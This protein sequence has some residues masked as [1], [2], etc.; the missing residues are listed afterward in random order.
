MNDSVLQMIYIEMCS[1]Q[2]NKIIFI[3]FND[4][5]INLNVKIYIQKVYKR[6]TQT[7]LNYGRKVLWIIFCRIQFN[8]TI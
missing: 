4:K 7:L 5:S 2:S 1:S 3:I 8:V 6:F